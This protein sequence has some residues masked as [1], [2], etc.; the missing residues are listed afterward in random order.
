MI[1]FILLTIQL[2]K[3]MSITRQYFLQVKNLHLCIAL[4]TY[5][6][7]SLYLPVE[8]NGKLIK[9][10]YLPIAL[11]G[12]IRL[13]N[14]N[15]GYTNFKIFYVGRS[16]Q[17]P[18]KLQKANFICEPQAILCYTRLNQPVNQKG[19]LSRVCFFTCKK[20]RSTLD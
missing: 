2:S 15:L 16:P 13:N 7:F 12:I 19:D 11:K 14:A 17:H 18:P 6:L 4:L 1:K 5:L 9:Y 8:A 10:N 3:G 20:M